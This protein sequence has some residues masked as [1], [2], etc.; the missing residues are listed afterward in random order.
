MK[1]IVITTLC[2]ILCSFVFAQKVKYNLFENIT[3][4]VCFKGP[5]ISNDNIN[6]VHIIDWSLGYKLRNKISIGVNM[7]DYYL[8][9]YSNHSYVNYTLFGV[10]IKYV[11]F[12]LAKNKHKPISFEPYFIFFPDIHS[13]DF[14]SVKLILS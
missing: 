1:K 12:D 4:S 11:L 2:V 9:N 6:S 7:D 8:F 5:P 14:T 10:D 3:G 13:R